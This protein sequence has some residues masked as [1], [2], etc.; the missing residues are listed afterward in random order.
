MYDKIHYNKKKK[1][2]KI[3]Y[4]IYRSLLKP[5]LF[6]LGVEQYRVVVFVLGIVFV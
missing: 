2:K 4:F 3:V 5:Q 6:V 1:E